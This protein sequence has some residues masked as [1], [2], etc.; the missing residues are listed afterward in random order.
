MAE[1]DPKALEL[2]AEASSL[3]SKELWEEAACRYEKML[4]LDLAIGE[5]AKT[6]A[7]LMQM[8][9]KQQQY[10]KA[11]Y[12]AV[13]AYKIIQRHGLYRTDEGA[14]MRGVIRGF[15]MRIRENNLQA[16]EDPRSIALVLHVTNPLVSF[17]HTVFGTARNALLWFIV[18][19]I[20]VAS[21]MFF[22]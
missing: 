13:L 6:F 7:N 9:E 15:L 14:Y 21:Y 3:R 2:E 12:V 20:I 22:K 18:L 11:I 10:E 5:K 17:V 4:D 8:Y 19:A 16:I 1:I